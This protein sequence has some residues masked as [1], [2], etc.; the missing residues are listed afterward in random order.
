MKGA[1]AALVSG[2]D[3]TSAE[4]T[5]AMTKIMDGVAT[6]AQIG[7]FLAGLRAKGET[8]DE[9]VAAVSVLRER[10]VTLPAGGDVIDTCGT[11]GDGLGTF[12]VSTAAAFVAA[13]AGAKVA[14]HGNRAASGKVGAADVLEAAGAVVDLGPDAA[15]RCL[16]TCGIT[17]LFA[18]TYHPAVRHVAA[19]RRELGFRTMFNLTG[20]LSNPAG[21]RRQVIGLYSREWLVTVAEVLRRLGSEHVLVVHGGDGSDE[22]TPAG[23]TSVV[24]L[25]GGEIRSYQV[26]PEDFAMRRCSPAD[27]AGGDAAENA[28]LLRAVLGGVSGPQSDAAALNAGAAIFVAGISKS[29]AGGVAR[30]R[31]I[32]AS[33]EAVQVLDAFV[34]CSQ[35]IASSAAEPEAEAEVT[36]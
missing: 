27:L 31:E 30:S 36:P 33:G 24:E 15:R 9:L 35:R 5:D 20:P 13:A 21:A 17:F 18:P 7:A 19:V 16:D 22:I 6:P 28:R 3:L 29:L 8:V 26:S 2:K 34:A 10:A 11:G 4:M 32:L 14:K 12:N 25:H 23:E 1:L